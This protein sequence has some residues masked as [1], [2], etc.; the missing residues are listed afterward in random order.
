MLRHIKVNKMIIHYQMVC[1][2]HAMYLRFLFV[3]MQ[4]LAEKKRS[5]AEAANAAV[6]NEDDLTG[7]EILSATGKLYF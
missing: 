3:Y 7:A 4:K 1:E 2:M 6:M 5:R